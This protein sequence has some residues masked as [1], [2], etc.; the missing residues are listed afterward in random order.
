MTGW[1]GGGLA[2]RTRSP[3]QSDRSSFDQRVRSATDS[4]AREHTVG[5]HGGTGRECHALHRVEQADARQ[6]VQQCGP[7]RSPR[8][9][10]DRARTRPA[11]PA[12]RRWHRAVRSVD[13]AGRARRT[14]PRRSATRCPTSRRRSISAAALPSCSST[15]DVGWHVARAVAAPPAAR[16]RHRRDP[17]CRCRSAAGRS[18][19]VRMSPSP[20]RAGNCIC[21]DGCLEHAARRRCAWA[22]PAKLVGRRQN[23]GH[24]APRRQCAGT[25]DGEAHC[26][27]GSP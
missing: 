11:R 8:R 4:A 3:P 7:A 17:D 20:S 21:F 16:R 25:V 9:R 1:A 19:G 15:A 23:E 13:G 12:A 27:R 5:R 26:L 14:P 18:G 22:T 2:M 24:G 6:A 10:Q